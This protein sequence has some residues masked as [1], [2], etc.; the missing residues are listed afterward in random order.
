MDTTA[1]NIIFDE[2]GNCNFCNNFLENDTKLES[3]Y[4][5]NK[6]KKNGNGKKYDCIVD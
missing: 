6:I 4:L 2:L 1:T 5:I 3:L